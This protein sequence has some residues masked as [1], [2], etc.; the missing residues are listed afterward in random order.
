LN[1]ALNPSTEIKEAQQLA[2]TNQ[3]WVLGKPAA[4]AAVGQ[5]AAG[6]SPISK[7]KFAASLRDQ[8]R[9][10]LILDTASPATA[11]QVLASSG[12]N[13]PRDLQAAIEGNALHYTL[14][15]DRATA[16]DRFGGFMSDSMGKQLAPLLAAALDMAARKSAPVRSAPNKVVIEGLDD[17]PREVSLPKP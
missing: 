8:F 17:G 10:D 2:A 1:F 9:M 13:A 4:F 12:K 7:I 15:L 3:V 5:P 16:L 14:Q 11:K 6:N